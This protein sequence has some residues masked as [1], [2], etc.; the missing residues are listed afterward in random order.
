MEYLNSSDINALIH[1]IKYQRIDDQLDKE[2]SLKAL[3]YC[4]V[5]YIDLMTLI[6]FYYHLNLIDNIIITQNLWGDIH[7]LTVD[8][9]NIYKEYNIDVNKYSLYCILNKLSYIHIYYQSNTC[10][11]LYLKYFNNNNQYYQ[12]NITSNLDS[13]AVAS[14]KAYV[15]NMFIKAEQKYYINIIHQIIKRASANISLYNL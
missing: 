14:I 9:K 5:N 15:K 8:N 10:F 2:D 11:Y 13:D 4:S 3:L 7:Q 12:I 1:Q 6:D